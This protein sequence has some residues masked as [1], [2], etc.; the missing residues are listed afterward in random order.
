MA[1]P[2]EEYYSSK[3]KTI[4]ASPKAIENMILSVIK[5]GA[6]SSASVVAYAEDRSYDGK[7]V[8]KRLQS[9]FDQNKIKLNK[10]MKWIIK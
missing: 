4:D 7:I 6:I 5:L 3:R 1:N 2:F 9:L 10:D 8:R